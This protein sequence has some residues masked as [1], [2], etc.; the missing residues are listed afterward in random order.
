MKHALSYYP[1]FINLRGRKCVVIGGGE[2]AL[3]KAESLLECDARV[4]VISPEICY[5]L[6]KLATDGKITVTERNYEAGDLAGAFLAIAATGDEEVN[7]LAAA[8]AEQRGILVNVVDA[9]ELCS[10]IVPSIVRRGYLTLAVSTGGVSP[11][12]ARKIRVKLEREF[13]EEYG[14]LTRL[15]G[16]VR[17]EIKDEGR[18]V[19]AE[20]WQEALDLESILELL[21]HGRR[22]DARRQVKKSLGAA[23]GVED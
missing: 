4:G 2:V 17:R 19:D 7:R 6:N 14:E 21:R 18:R 10:F 11:A 13:G 15:I 23:V 22:E 1:V 3:R 9:P 8:E 20:R 12:L 5:G 16:E